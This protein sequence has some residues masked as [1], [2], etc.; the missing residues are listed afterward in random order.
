MPCVALSLKG[1]GVGVGAGTFALSDLMQNMQ[2]KQ[3]KKPTMTAII[4]PIADGVSCAASFVAFVAFV[5]VNVVRCERR[6]FVALRTTNATNA[7]VALRTT[8]VRC[9]AN[10]ATNATNAFVASFNAFVASFVVRCA[11]YSY[12]L[13]GVTDHGTWSLWSVPAYHACTPFRH[14]WKQPLNCFANLVFSNCAALRR[15]THTRARAMGAAAGG[16]SR[17]TW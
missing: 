12:S 13:H 6:S 9:V 3:T 8:F 14:I 10:D 4:K 7:F 16:A 5:N 17:S 1:R 11:A 2:K 15:H